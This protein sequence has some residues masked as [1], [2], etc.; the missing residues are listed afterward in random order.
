[1]TDVPQWVEIL[2]KLAVPA[3]AGVSTFY[4]YLQYRRAKGWKSS[5][6]AAGLVKQLESDKELAFACRALDWGVGPLLVPEYYRPLIL[7]RNHRAG[8]GGDALA[9]VMEHDTKLLHAAMTPQLQSIVVDD[10]RGLIYRACFDRLFQH[11]ADAY[12]LLQD[13]Q[14]HK[15]DIQEFAYWLERIARYEYPPPGVAKE[16]VFQPFLHRFNYTGVI[17]LGRAFGVGGWKDRS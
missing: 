16:E 6:L 2:N 1:M 4:V 7:L 9:A 3:I 15:A 14:I 12:R 5:D 17:S 8:S 13:K 10:P 11:L